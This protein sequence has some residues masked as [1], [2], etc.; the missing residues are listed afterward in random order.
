MKA[1]WEAKRV[2]L[3]MLAAAAV[4]LL[5][6]MVVSSLGS[7]S[8]VKTDRGGDLEVQRAGA[9]IACQDMVRDRLKSPASAQFSG[10]VAS[11]AGPLFT[12]RGKVDSQNSFGAMLRS[13]FS[14]QL[15]FDG[16]FFTGAAEV[17]E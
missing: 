5:V 3:L 7:G 14:C 17:R 12:V 8:P 4:A 1:Y 11:G 6:M 15:H 2:P 10:V 13:S 16:E 9:K